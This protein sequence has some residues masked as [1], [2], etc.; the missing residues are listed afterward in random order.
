VRGSAVTS[1]P[2]HSDRAAAEH[3]EAVLDEFI[4]RLVGAEG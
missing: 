3:Q 2:A 4:T 1:S